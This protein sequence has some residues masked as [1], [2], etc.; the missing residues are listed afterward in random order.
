MQAENV[1]FHKYGAWIDLILV[2]FCHKLAIPDV[3]G[4]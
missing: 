3:I 1:A 4:L 2:D